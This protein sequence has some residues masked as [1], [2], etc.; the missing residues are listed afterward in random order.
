M[1]LPNH[2]LDLP[3]DKLM[4]VLDEIPQLL[5]ELQPL[6]DSFDLT[7]GLTHSQQQ[8]FLLSCIYTII[9]PNPTHTH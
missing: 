1:N 6:M 8:A 7:N 4:K 3:H 9:L 2:Y 5:T